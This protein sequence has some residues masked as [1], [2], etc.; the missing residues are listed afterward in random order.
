MAPSSDRLVARL[1][2]RALPEDVRRALHGLRHLDRLD[3]L[4][5]LDALDRLDTLDRLD[6]LD[7]L[8]RLSHLDRLD[9]LGELA[10]LEDLERELTAVRHGVTDRD[11]RLDHL[12]R[13]LADPATRPVRPVYGVAVPGDPTAG[14]WLN[15]CRTIQ[16]YLDPVSDLRMLDVGSSGG[17]VSAY[18]AARGATVVGW[19]P[20]PIQAELA[21]TA[22]AVSGLAPAIVT[23]DLDVT[24]LDAVRPAVTDVVLLLGVGEGSWSHR[25]PDGAALLAALLGQGLTVIVETE[26]ESV[27]AAAL[28]AELQADEGGLDVDLLGT[29]AD[30]RTGGDPTTLWALRPVQATIAVNGTDYVYATKR[31][32]AYDGSPMAQHG[33]GRRYYAGPDHI[34]KEYRLDG[35]HRQVNRTQILAEVDVLARLTGESGVP[36]LVDFEIVPERARLVLRRI[37][38]ELLADRLDDRRP[39]SEMYAI[40][41]DVLRALVGLE[42]R[43]LAHN[44]VRSW[45]VL[46]DAGR[47]TL[48]DYGLVSAGDG[49]GDVR[50]LLWVV[51]AMVTGEREDFDRRQDTLPERRLFADDPGLDK[52]H[53]AVSAD[54]ATPRA[55][56]AALGLG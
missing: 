36:E 46:V 19:E 35:D 10:R 21:R 24:T 54:S 2:R 1:L 52:L 30:E 44:D 31:V 29:L 41:T 23:H 4:G 14:H 17:F 11:S 38:G 51:K 42:R 47:A 55:V 50:D 20:D 26:A 56:F 22:A 7:E 33:A 32:E 39:P 16:H 28:L 49:G 3:E 40:A 12:L 9:G 25:R 43:G 15:R 48:I 13:A 53:Q 34:V 45:N 6:R 27:D 5:R 37:P 18:F 8:E